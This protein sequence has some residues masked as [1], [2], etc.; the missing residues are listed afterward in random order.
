MKRGNQRNYLLVAVDDIKKET[1]RGDDKRKTPSS[2]IL[3]E[4]LANRTII[5]DV[6][7]YYPGC[8]HK[9]YATA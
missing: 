3:I 7:A 4:Y 5:Q 9:I 2:D 6:I 8:K 1:I